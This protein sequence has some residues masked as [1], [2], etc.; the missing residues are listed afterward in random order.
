MIEQFGRIAERND[1]EWMPRNRELTR[2]DELY[3]PHA[4]LTLEP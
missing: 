2:L 4:P 3:C 1:A